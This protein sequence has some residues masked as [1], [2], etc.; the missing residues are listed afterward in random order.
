M[1]QVKSFACV[2]IIFMILNVLLLLMGIAM[3]AVGCYVQLSKGN[4][5]ILLPEYEFINVVAVMVASGIIVLVVSIIGFCGACMMSQCMLIIYFTMVLVVFALQISVGIIAYIYRDEVNRSLEDQLLVGLKNRKVQQSWDLIQK[6]FKCCGVTGPED[7]SKHG[8]YN[9]NNVP[10]SCCQ[11]SGCGIGGVNA[12]KAGC[13][14][15]AKMFISD[16]FLALGATGIALGLLQLFL[17]A[18]SL[19]MICCLRKGKHIKSTYA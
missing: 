4:V 16:N 9:N 12:Y 1:P 10:D 3:I 19:A 2:R 18:I 15:Q 14:N 6:N 7:W 11:Y 5:L 13:L 17:M 8:E